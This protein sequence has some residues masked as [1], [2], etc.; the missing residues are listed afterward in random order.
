MTILLLFKLPFHLYFSD[1]CQQTTF[2]KRSFQNKQIH[3]HSIFLYT[4]FSFKI[5][6]SSF[7]VYLS[8]ILL[9]TNL[10]GQKLSKSAQLGGPLPQFNSLP[11]FERGLLPLQRL[12]DED[13]SVLGPFCAK[14]ITYFLYPYT[15]C[16]FRVMKKISNEFHQRALTITFFWWLFQ[17]QH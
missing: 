7:L 5:L 6:T 10:S 14:V 2:S 3:S 4:Y 11:Y 1:E 13:I 9:D 8:S 12:C 17:A 16:S 15:K